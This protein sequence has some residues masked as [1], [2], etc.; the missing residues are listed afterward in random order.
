MFSLND[1]KIELSKLVYSPAETITGKVITYIPSPTKVSQIQLSFYW[2]YIPPGFQSGGENTGIIFAKHNIILA[3][4]VICQ[5]YMYDFEIQIPANIYPESVE[6]SFSLQWIQESGWEKIG[7]DIISQL[8]GS[9]QLSPGFRFFL[10][11]VID[12]PWG[13]NVSK[14]LE[15]TINPNL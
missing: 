9:R 13:K 15:I 2:L 11:V 7:Y 14:T 12:I 3:S 6:H 8:L 1:A 4:N 10:D 5:S